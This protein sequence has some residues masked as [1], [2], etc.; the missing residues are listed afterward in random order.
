MENLMERN[1][2][3]Q[4]GFNRGAT[5]AGLVIGLIVGT[6]LVVA[7]AI[8]TVNGVIDSSNLTGTVATVVGVIPIMLAIIPV[9][10]VAQAF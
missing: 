6:I 2:S 3:K 7:V 4:Y 1:I 9:V 10:L 8:P 5:I